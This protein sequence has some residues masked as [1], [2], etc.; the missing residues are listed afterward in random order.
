MTLNLDNVE[1]F[2]NEKKIAIKRPKDLRTSSLNFENICKRFNVPAEVWIEI[3][4]SNKIH[5]FDAITTIIVIR[6]HP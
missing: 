6:K 2:F 1:K 3:W 5:S 4:G